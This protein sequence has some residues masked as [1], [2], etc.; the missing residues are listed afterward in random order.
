MALQ[1]TNLQT[2]KLTE[3]IN[4]HKVTFDQLERARKSADSANLAKSNYVT[5]LSHELRTPLN[6]ILGYAQILQKDK[7]LIEEQKEQVAVLRRNGEH[8]ATMIEGLLEISKIEAGKL[9]LNADQVR[10]D[11]MLDQLIA[12]FKQQAHTK[13][14]TFNADI[15]TNL[16]KSIKV[17][18]KRLRQILINLLS[19]AI[20]FTERGGITLSLKYRGHVA[21]F[22]IEDT[23]YGIA[24][25]KIPTI[26]QPFERGENAEKHSIPGS[27][28]GLAI[29]RQLADM[30]GAEID[31]QSE[32][33]V[34][35]TFTLLLQAS[36]TETDVTPHHIDQLITGYKGKKK[37]ILVIDDNED[38]RRLIYDLLNPINFTV[39]ECSDFDITFA[40][41]NAPIDLV[42]LDV[43]LGHKSGWDVARSIRKYFSH[44]PIIMV[45]ANARGFYD[46]MP[47]QRLHDDYIEKA[48]QLDAL[49]EKIGNLLELNWVYDDDKTCM[50]KA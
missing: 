37:T 34:G 7:A 35:S 3:E 28:L 14:L 6:V 29:C 2:Q 32:L 26:F 38:H 42:L 10:L 25:H 50:K 1:E 19:N 33:G 27:G 30:M 13:G 36:P 49:I 39:L 44:L 5:A 18:E 22:C 40:R 16:P 15:P 43:R 17:D 48:L 23:G 21:R 24:P 12:M 46:D 11:V 4:A 20:K 9:A 8:L 45:S 47:S 41:Q 31:V